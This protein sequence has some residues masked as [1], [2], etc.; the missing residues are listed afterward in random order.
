MSPL[1]HHI[2]THHLRLTLLGAALSLALVGCQE[3]KTRLK[4]PATPLPS[5]VKEGQAPKALP[6]APP[7]GS[8]KG[9][10]PLPGAPAAHT[11]PIPRTATL[12]GDEVLG[13]V[14]QEGVVEVAGFKTGVGVSDLDVP[15]GSVAE[16]LGVDP[17]EA[18][19]DWIGMEVKPRYRRLSKF[20]PTDVYFIPAE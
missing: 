8:E 5:G 7:A 14:G 19:L 6:T 12:A 15:A 4:L 16:R 10:K 20:K 13:A 11:D 18:S 3:D 17:Y 9:T 2:E 1:T